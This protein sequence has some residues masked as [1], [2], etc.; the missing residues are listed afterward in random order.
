[1][2]LGAWTAAFV[3]L[4]SEDYDGI[5]RATRPG[6]YAALARVCDYPSLWWARAAKIPFGSADLSIRIPDAPATGTVALLESGRRD[7][8]SQLLLVRERPD[9]ARLELVED[10]SSVVVLSAAFP[11][12]GAVVR[13]RVVAPWLYPPAPHPFWDAYPDPAVRRAMQGGF[14]LQVDGGAPAAADARSEDAEELTP[15]V[16]A[17]GDPGSEVGWVES[18]VRREKGAP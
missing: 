7:H 8:L 5:A 4:A 15:R 2:A 3:F 17:R 13:A 11:A 14:M 12:R 1:V 18:V 6:A 16:E 9:E 10:G